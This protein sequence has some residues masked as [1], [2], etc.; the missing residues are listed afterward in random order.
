MPNKKLVIFDFCGT[1]IRFQTADRYVQFCVERLKGYKVIQLRHMVIK[2][3]DV[4][5]VF[6]IYNHI[7][8]I[9]NWRKR[10]VLWQLK[11]VAYE[12]CDALAAAYFEEELLPNVVQPIVEL[13]RKHIAVKDRVCIL[14]GGYDIYIKYFAQYFGVKE[15][16]SSKIAFREGICLGKMEGADCMRENKLDYLQPLLDGSNTICYTDSKSDMVLLKIVDEP[17]VVSKGQPQQWATELNY[18]QII[19]T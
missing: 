9:N 15:T 11:G 12:K 3:M 10:M 19:W 18:K 4:M 6:K 13:L 14:S 17:V 16:A 7:R 5:R 2:M 1:L 8:P